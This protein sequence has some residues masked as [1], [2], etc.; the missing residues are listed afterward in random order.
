MDNLLKTPHYI[1]LVL[2]LLIL[3]LN[4]SG[5]CADS[6]SLANLEVELFQAHMPVTS[7]LIKGPFETI[8][9][10]TRHFGSGLY[11]IRANKK[12]IE[13]LDKK[14]KNQILFA[15]KYLL[16]NSTN[17]NGINIEYLPGISR[18][19]K[20]NIA[21]TCD[22]KGNLHFVNIVPEQEYILSVVGSE[23]IVDAPKEALKA[24]A[25]LV[26]TWL[27]GRKPNDY[28]ND[29]TSYQAYL[30]NAYVSDRVREAVIDVLDKVLFYKT[31]PIKVYY[32]S[33][34]GGG[35]SS[36]ALLLKPNEI[37][38]PYLACVKCQN[39]FMSP[40]WKNKVIVIPKNIFSKYFGDTYP[41]IVSVDKAGRPMTVSLKNGKIYTGYEF[42]LAT[43]QK[44]GWDKMPGTRY[45]ISA[46]DNN[47]QNVR[48]ISNGAGHGVGLCQ[49]GA[50]Q[51]AKAGKSCEQILYYYFPGTK[52]SSH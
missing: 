48:L 5:Y 32:H 22:D 46:S 43:G 30:G 7:C 19:Y 47:I 52:I 17:K 28:L 42:W 15:T 18:F 10:A 41:T 6:R 44:L 36:G 37:S 9:F 1:K 49:W 38:P 4:S 13:I 23:M 14:N 51:L 16:L 27:A 25:V 45:K 8:K 40:F 39:C 20:G 35:T 11:M 50:C 3:L 24:Q 29:T 31:S 34:C 12:Q 33:T 2:L 21:I 26:Q